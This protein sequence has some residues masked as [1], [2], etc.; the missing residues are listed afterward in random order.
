MSSLLP[1]RGIT[2]S[3]EAWYS[4]GHDCSDH[5]SLSTHLSGGG[6]NKEQERRDAEAEKL[7]PA[8]GPGSV[9]ADALAGPCWPHTP[10]DTS[11]LPIFIRTP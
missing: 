3:W 1:Q 9:Q 6:S 8:L 10:V 11:L 4:D 2:S 5:Y 7:G